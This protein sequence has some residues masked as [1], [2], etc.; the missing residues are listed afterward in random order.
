MTPDDKAEILMRCG[1]DPQLCRTVEAELGVV[2]FHQAV[3]L[4]A[5]QKFKAAQQHVVALQGALRDAIEL[6]QEGWGYADD[7]FYTKWDVH[8]RLEAIRKVLGGADAVSPV[9]E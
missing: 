3:A 6:A 4:S 8:E 2:E 1:D 9:Q 7:H 5:T